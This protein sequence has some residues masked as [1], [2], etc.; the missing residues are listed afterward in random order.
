[1]SSPSQASDNID[2]APDGK[3]RGAV[4]DENTN[5]PIE[6]AT[7]ALYRATDD[8]LITGAITDY[9]GHFKIAQPEPGEYYLTISFIGLEEIKSEP[10]FVKEER[11]N[12]NLGNF[13]LRP[14]ASNLDEVEVVAKQAPIEYRIDK[15]VVNVDRQ[16]T[17]E[18]GT[19]VDVLE[20]VPSVQVDV[21]GNVTLRGSSGF[22]V[23][24]DGKPTILDPSDVLRQIPTSSIENIEI[25]T[26][27]SAKYEPDGATGII[28]VITKKNRLD[29]L[30]GIVN[31]N[32]GTYGRYGGDINLSYRLNKL[33]FVFGAN[34][35][36]RNRPGYIIDER[37]TNANDTSYFINSEGD[38]ERGR[39]NGSIRAGVEYDIS[40]NDFISLSG[41]IG[42]WRSEG[43]ST[44]KYDEWTLP[45]TGIYSYN[46][47][48]QT[49]RDGDYFAIDAIYQRTFGS[50]KSAAP[51][52]IRK[53]PAGG[54]TGGERTGQREQQAKVP[55]TL[56]VE[57]L[58]RSRDMHEENINR[59][60]NL[61][62]ITIGG[63]KNIE[64]GPSQST[65]VNIDYTLPVGKEDKFEAGFQLR[66][67]KSTDITELWLYNDVTGEIEFTDD[68]SNSTEYYRNIYAAYALYGGVVGSFGYQLGLRTEYTD[69]QIEMTGEQP[70]GI[71]RWD[72]FPTVHLS[73]NLPLEQQLMASYA[74]RIDRPRGWWLEPFITVQDAFNVRQ[75]NPALEP[76]YIDSYELGYLKNFNDNF[77]SLEGYYR[78]VHNKVERIR[79]VYSE[80][81]MLTRP[82]NIG[83]DYSLGLE[84]MLTVSPFQWWDFELGGNFFNYR[85]DGEL[86]YRE[87][88]EVITETIDRSSTNWN[89]RLNNTFRLWK[90][91]IFQLNYRYNSASVTAQGTS[92]SFM[93]LDAAFKVMFLNKSLS[94]NLQGQ[95]LLGT[96][97][98]EWESSG[99]GFYTYSK[100]DPKSPMGIVTVSY[101]F[102]N[103]K[104]RRNVFGEGAGDEF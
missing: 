47:S 5:T 63:T 28:N 12:I 20:N 79:S 69:R 8:E 59:L 103:Y 33:N 24:I 48:D 52:T 23:L 64:K 85:M 1:M 61:E 21:E 101:R 54:D 31:A 94:I 36:E 11:K 16:I 44:L 76:E 37:I 95:D 45:E 17:A 90:N 6:Y 55:H 58:F 83:N 77:F 68:Y 14:S 62:D 86:L 100:F 26:N 80:N 74:R 73:L 99:A 97:R 19:A 93:T 102:N 13:L 49:T 42:N 71:N 66:M 38:T 53:G 9:L 3:I 18:A 43:S 46:S 32:A 70:F 88:N 56:K 65:R 40:N 30:S 72:Y 87:G 82:E 39:A 10:F 2:P 22:T 41:R 92:K 4:V 75:G 60:S 96:A 81:V 27:P 15:K 29:G 35:N 104:S 78:V 98:R 89:S 7:V 34:Y 91:G 50:R 51:D 84:A 57:Y 25:I 67:G